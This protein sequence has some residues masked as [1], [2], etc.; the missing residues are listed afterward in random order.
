M[1]RLPDTCLIVYRCF[2]TCHMMP[3]KEED[4]Q[5]VVTWRAITARPYMTAELDAARNARDAANQ[6]LRGEMDARAVAEARAAEADDARERVNE[7]TAAAEV[8][9]GRY[10]PLRHP[11]PFE[12]SGCLTGGIRKWGTSRAERRC[13]W[14][15]SGESNAACERS[16]NSN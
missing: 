4:S 7:L 5:C 16:F 10:C 11:I 6:S 2:F 1:R 3:L 14:C 13:V 12:P 15:L 9:P 8:G